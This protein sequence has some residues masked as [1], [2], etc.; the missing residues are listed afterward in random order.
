MGN[1]K[2]AWR[3]NS[4]IFAKEENFKSFLR[5]IDKFSDVSDEVALYV[6]DDIFPHLS[7]IEDKIKQ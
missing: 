2:L 5:L 1:F 4:K 6:T 7:P 3:I